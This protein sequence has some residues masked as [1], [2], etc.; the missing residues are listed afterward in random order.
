MPFDAQFLSTL[1]Y[2][3]PPTNAE[4]ITDRPPGPVVIFEVENQLSPADLYCYLHAR[5]GPPNGFQNFLR[6][7]DSDNLIHWD[8]T[9]GHEG[10]VL[11]RTGNELPNPVHRIWSTRSP[12]A[13]G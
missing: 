9:L 8:W 12:I 2:L 6:K 11:Q 3:P 13:S 5:F 7:D 1:T 4:L 10:G